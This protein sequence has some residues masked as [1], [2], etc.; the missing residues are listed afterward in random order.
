MILSPSDIA[1]PRGVSDLLPEAAAKIGSIEI[2]LL[3]VFELW[4]FRRIITPRLEYEDVLATGMGEEL[5]GKTYRFDDRQSGRLL[6]IPPDITP[7]IARIAATRMSSLPLPHRISYSDRVLRQTEIQAGRSREIFQTG[8]EL[9][10][11]DSPEADAEMI[12]MAIEAMKVLGLDNFTIDLGQVEFCQGVFQASG[13]SDEPLRQMREAVSRKDSSA[14]ASLLKEHTVSPESAR[15]LSALPRLF[16]GR[17][18][19]DIAQGVVTNSRSQAALDNLRQV[20]EILD[21][22]GVADLL[23]ID[24][25]ETRGLDYHSGITF[26]GF[27]TG[28]GEPVCSGG[29]YDNLTARYGFAAPATGFTFNLL[30]LLQTIER[31]PELHVSAATDFLLFNTHSDRRNVLLIARQLRSLG[32]TTARDIIRRDYEQSLEY[33]KKM[34]I[35]CMLVVGD[36]KEPCRAIRSIDGCVIPIENS[37]LSG[38][39]L[40]NYIEESQGEN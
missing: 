4:G 37:M 12:V 15:E 3:R 40:M 14:V 8:V 1:L 7:Q 18:V 39:G 2:G 6:A 26:E 29:R 17:D 33:A 32:Y 31:R 21:I 28:F 13:L 24:L 22:H 27:V 36:D 35:R 10:G 9:I 25:G 23:S 16:G 34:N 19:L 11:L 5:K 38:P 20:L 30:N